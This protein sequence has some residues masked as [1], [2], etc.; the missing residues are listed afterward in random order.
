[1][2]TYIIHL[3]EVGETRIATR[4]L[5][6]NIKAFI[7]EELEDDKLEWDSACIPTSTGK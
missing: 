2:T 6:R 3:G 1:M 7:N 4:G 5:Q